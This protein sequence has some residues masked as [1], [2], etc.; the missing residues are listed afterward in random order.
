ML[1]RVDLHTHTTASDGTLTGRELVQL[2]ASHGVRVLAIT[3]HDSTDALGEAGAEAE[4]LGVILVPGIEINCEADGAELHVLGYFVDAGARWFQEFLREQRA[5]RRTRVLRMAARL[6]ELGLPVDAAEVFALAGNGAAG[7]P[8][9]AQVMV[10]RGYVATVREA[11]ERYLRVGG[12]AWVP[13]HRLAPADAVAVVRRA[14]GVAV[15]AHPGL[16]DRDALIPGLVEAGLEG[17]EA[18]YPEHSA[19]Q[20]E[21]YLDLCRRLAL[22][23]TGGSDFHGPGSGYQTTPGTP[24]VPWEAWEA[25]RLRARGSGASA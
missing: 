8:H 2:A 7:R 14:G 15:L 23:A 16:A 21:H 24:L 4:R 3:D 9:V 18:Y 6:R 17:L 10:R 20:T 13:R 19:T 25:L 12:P 22:L 5:E 1:G 11:F